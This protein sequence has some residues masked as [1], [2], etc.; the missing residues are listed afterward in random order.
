MPNSAIGSSLEPLY[1]ALRERDELD[2]KTRKKVIAAQIATAMQRQGLSK[3]ALAERMNTSRTVIYRLLDPSDV[4]VTLETLAKTSK[5]LSLHL[6][7][8]L[9]NK[10]YRH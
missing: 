10:A 8:S 4:S 6:D 9:S 5:A 1:D 7:V 2:L 3:T